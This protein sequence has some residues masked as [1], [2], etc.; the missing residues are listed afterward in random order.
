MRPE[1]RI[2]YLSA[3]E[4]ASTTDDLGPF[5]RLMGERLVETLADYVTARREG[6]G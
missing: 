2:A 4:T 6:V 3:L 1:D 5:R